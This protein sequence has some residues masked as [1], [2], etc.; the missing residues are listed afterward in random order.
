MA[1]DVDDP[2][3]AFQRQLL[4]H[5]DRTRTRGIE[6]QLVEARLHPRLPGQVLRQV[7]GMELHIGEAVMR[8]IGAGALHQAGLAFHANDI[9]IARRPRQR[10]V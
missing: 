3:Q 8:G 2:L 9:A 10:H 4:Q 6:Q 1:A 5:L 7:G